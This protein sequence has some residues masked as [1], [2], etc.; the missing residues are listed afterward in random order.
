M[1]DHPYVIKLYEV[2]YTP[3]DI[4]LITELAENGELFN[5]IVSRK[6]IDVQKARYY[7]QQFI[8]AVDYL[9]KQV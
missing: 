7:F 5:Y 9:H 2:I 4:F 6:R 1:L 3:T 8:G